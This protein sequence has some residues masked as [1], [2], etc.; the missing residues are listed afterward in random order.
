MRN[1]LIAGNWKMNCGISATNKLLNGIKEITTS[2]PDGVDGLVC[3]PSISLQTAADVLED[4]EGMTLGAQNVHFE[5]NGAYTGE[6]STQMLNEV[7]SEYVI[8]GH[9]ERR[10]YFGETDK[11]VN[12][13]VLKSLEDGL[14]TVICVG[15]SLKER[16][17]DEH[18]LR[19]RKQVQAALTGVEDGDATNVV[20][21]YEPI[22][23]IGT[24]ETATPDQAQEMH[25]MIRSVLEGVFN[26]ESAS[27]IQILYGGSMKP[28]NAEELLQQPDVDGGLIGGASL[29]ADSFTEI[30]DIAKQLV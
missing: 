8:L 6:I 30:I 16:K 28:H 22:W 13:K 15:E 4:I 29:K 1:F 23:A 27:K 2:L 26:Q 14:K 3:P 9:S 25:K 12:A 19:V 21:A 20:I 24:G 5:D 7:G 17:A 18:K 11:I 10:E